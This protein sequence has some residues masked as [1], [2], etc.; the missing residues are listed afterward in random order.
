MPRVLIVA[1]PEDSALAAGQV[2]EVGKVYDMPPDSAVRWK[3]RGVAVDAPADEAS[4]PGVPS[5]SAPTPAAAAVSAEMSIAGQGD[6]EPAVA[7]EGPAQ[8]PSAR[9]RGRR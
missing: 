7:I 5:P 9:P 8:E 1:R 3:R 4:G 2:L 6:H